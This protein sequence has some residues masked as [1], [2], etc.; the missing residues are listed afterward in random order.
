MSI[1]ERIQQGDESALPHDLLQRDASLFKPP[2]NADIEAA[3]VSFKQDAMATV[4]ALEGSIAR[5]AFSE[6]ERRY[7]DSLASFCFRLNEITTN[8][9][10]GYTVGKAAFA[11]GLAEAVSANILDENIADV[12]TERQFRSFHAQ[13]ADMIGLVNRVKGALRMDESE[14]S[15]ET[16]LEDI[17]NSRVTIYNRRDLRAFTEYHPYTPLGLP[18]YTIAKNTAYRAVNH[19]VRAQGAMASP[20]MIGELERLVVQATYAEFPPNRVLTP[21]DIRYREYWAKMVTM[22]QDFFLR[23][24]SSPVF[25]FGNNI[26]GEVTR[27]SDYNKRFRQG[28]ALRAG[29]FFPDAQTAIAAQEAVPKSVRGVLEKVLRQKDVDAALMNLIATYRDSFRGGFTLRNVGQSEGEAIDE[30]LSLLDHDLYYVAIRERLHALSHLLLL[31]F[32]G[33]DEGEIE[34]FFGLVRDRV[35]TAQDIYRVRAYFDRGLLNDFVRENNIMADPK[36]YILREAAFYP[37]N[38]G[39]REVFLEK[40]QPHV[41]ARDGNIE[42]ILDSWYQDMAGRKADRIFAG[43]T[44]PKDV[45]VGSRVVPSQLQLLPFQYADQAWA[46]RQTYKL[47]TDE[48]LS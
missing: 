33:A 8:G 28:T 14:V 37:R 27:E 25:L 35:K 40:Q 46:T 23:D 26:L 29:N 30:S 9:N 38:G 41:V 48:R 24:V 20:F 1:S 4:D 45:L 10:D 22:S 31:H 16:F 36:A 21:E 43:L 32:N 15:F 3:Q 6:S 13:A 34:N 18:I 2:E 17:H 44:V 5:L 42:E 19:T 7:L 12:P 47:H 11:Y 39:R